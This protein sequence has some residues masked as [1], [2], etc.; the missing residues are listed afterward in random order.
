MQP[1]CGGTEKE[2]DTVRSCSLRRLDQIGGAEVDSSL[3]LSQ[4]A[5]CRDGRTRLAF[6]RWRGTRSR[7]TEFVPIRKP[8]KGILPAEGALPFIG[9]EFLATLPDKCLNGPDISTGILCAIDP[10]SQS[11]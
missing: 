2:A 6:D 8:I 9:I 5:Q 3:S 1:G 10:W 7:C 4:R 11:L